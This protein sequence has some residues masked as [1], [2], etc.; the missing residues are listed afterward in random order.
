MKKFLETTAAAVFCMALAVPLLA[1][2]Y[3]A[4]QDPALGGPGAQTGPE[5]APLLVEGS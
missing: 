5:E 1:Q 4:D 3:E 2:A